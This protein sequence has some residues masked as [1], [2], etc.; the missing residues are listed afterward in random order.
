MGV[1]PAVHHARGRWVSRPAGCLAYDVVVRKHLRSSER[2]LRQAIRQRISARSPMRCACADDTVGSD[3]ATGE[4][5]REMYRPLI[6]LWTPLWMAEEYFAE[7]EAKRA[8]ET[9]YR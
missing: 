9:R 6:Q 4:G 1:R 8:D 7:R 5:K 3:E 2:L